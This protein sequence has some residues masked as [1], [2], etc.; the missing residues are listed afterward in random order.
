VQALEVL[1]AVLPQAKPILNDLLAIAP[2]FTQ[3]HG[4]PLYDNDQLHLGISYELAKQTDRGA[5]IIGAAF[6]ERYLE[7]LLKQ[8]FS[9]ND[10]ITDSLFKGTQP[11]G[12]FSAKTALAYA[13]GVIGPKAFEEITTIRKIRNDFAHS[14]TPTLNSFTE[15]TFKSDSIRDRCANLW[16]P[17]DFADAIPPDTLQR[18]YDSHGSEA[19][20]RFM[21]AVGRLA[22]SF[23]FEHALTGDNS[24]S[25]APLHLL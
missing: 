13:I 6:V 7:L 22:L 19:R 25:H 12:T 8:R 5:A 21:I 1:A 15:L 4:T 16:T 18:I 17:D 2:K 24:D 14:I 11:L 10:E 9:V 20:A 23:H 3:V